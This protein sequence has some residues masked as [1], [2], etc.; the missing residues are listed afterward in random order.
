MGNKAAAD[1]GAQAAIGNIVNNSISGLIGQLCGNG[2]VVIH[3]LHINAGGSSVVDDAP[4]GLIAYFDLV[5]W[6]QD[7]LSEAERGAIEDA[8]GGEVARDR[9]TAT[10]RSAQSW[11]RGI[12]LRIGA[13]HPLLASKIRAKAAGIE[14]GVE[15]DDYWQRQFETVRRHWLH[16]DFEQ[17]RTDLRDIAYRMREEHALPDVRKTYVALL[18]EFNHADPYYTDVMA[19]VLPI[20]E[21]RPGVIQATLSKG[22]PA[23]DPER[24]RHAMYYGEIIGDL[25]RVKQGRS[26]GLFLG[27]RGEQ[28]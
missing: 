24:F 22:C 10:S 16:Q 26:Y 19:V 20:V 18:A 21:S 11:L 1:N 4:S 15:I 27:T 25:K 9:I 2:T 23:F 3:H 6:W 14:T 17:A 12:A 8:I 7:V 5:A 28:S 13:V